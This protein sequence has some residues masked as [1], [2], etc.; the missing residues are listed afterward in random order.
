M[1]FFVILRIQI[2]SSGVFLLCVLPVSQLMAIGLA[3][4]VS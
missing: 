4:A 3:V 2:Q 1:S